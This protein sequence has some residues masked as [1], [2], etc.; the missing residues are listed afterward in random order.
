MNRIVLSDICASW[1]RGVLFKF[2]LRTRGEPLHYHFE[3]VTRLSIISKLHIATT[4][5]IVTRSNKFHWRTVQCSIHLCGQRRTSDLFL[6]P[7]EGLEKSRNQ[8]FF[9]HLLHKLVFMTSVGVMSSLS[10]PFGYQTM[11]SRKRKILDIKPRTRHNAC[12]PDG[13]GV[14]YAA[15]LQLQWTMTT[16]LCLCIHCSV[17]RNYCTKPVI[18]INVGSHFC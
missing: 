18:R 2:V 12:N 16:G 7:S 14:P 17:G 9:R 3:W 6:N 11:N 8:S 4:W 15:S 5:L 10:F 13:H 1:Y